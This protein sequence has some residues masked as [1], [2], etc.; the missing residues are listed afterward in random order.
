[1]ASIC[2]NS[3]KNYNSRNKAKAQPKTRTKKARSDAADSD[4]EASNSDPPTTTKPPK[5]ANKVA[6]TPRPTITAQP[7]HNT[8]L[9]PNQL[10]VMPINPIQNNN[11]ENQRPNI[12]NP[13]SAHTILE[14]PIP[15]AKLPIF[16]VEDLRSA[17]YIPTSALKP[18]IPSRPLPD[19]PQFPKMTPTD[20]GTYRIYLMSTKKGHLAYS[21]WDFTNFLQQIKITLFPKD[22]PYSWFYCTEKKPI[23]EHFRYP[24]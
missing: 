18:Q 9:K 12:P 19:I 1:M 2:K 14:A 23:M 20:L 13:P 17:D 21:E 24:W 11:Q 8:S 5:L 16:S 10:Q 6:Q 4:S 3:V 22:S 15:N 7:A